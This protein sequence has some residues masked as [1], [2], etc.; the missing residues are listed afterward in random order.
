MTADPD[1]TPAHAH[2]PAPH[3]PQPASEPRAHDE[4][5]AVSMTTVRAFAHRMRSLAATVSAAADYMLGDGG[6]SEAE[7]EML[8][9]IAEQGGRI[10]GLL[11]DF[12]V[13]ISAPREPASGSVDIY[14]IARQIVRDL[15][16]EAQAIGAWLVFDAGEAIPPVCGDR[17]PLRQAVIGALRSVIALTRPGERVV[18]RLS[19]LGDA[20]GARIVELTISVHSHD[21]QLADRA[22]G[23]TLDDL[24]LDAARRICRSHGGELRLMRDRPGVLCVLPAAPMGA[25]PAAM[26]ARRSLLS[27]T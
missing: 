26:G 4:R 12:L 15:A 10:D 24:T 20:G 17:A 19:A 6:R 25:R 8:G 14:A 21:D 11:D 23:L 3:V 2:L 13:V 9:I 27:A 18:A 22:R 5:I 16:R 7:A 1:A